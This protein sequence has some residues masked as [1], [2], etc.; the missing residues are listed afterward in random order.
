MRPH[1]PQ[2]PEPELNLTCRKNSLP[3]TT[4]VT[5]AGMR[6]PCPLLLEGS[7]ASSSSAPGTTSSS[8]L[9]FSQICT[10]RQTASQTASAF[11]QQSI[12]AF[13]ASRQ[14]G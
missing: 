5:M 12:L 2:R 6:S 4:S 7:P 9:Q 14:H 8:G 10:A 13:R 3:L 11:A 1:T